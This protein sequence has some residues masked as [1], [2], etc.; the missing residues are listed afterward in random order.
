MSKEEKLEWCA[1]DLNFDFRW[2]IHESR[3]LHLIE[4]SPK[5]AERLFKINLKEGTSLSTYVQHLLTYKW[6]KEN[7]KENMSILC[8]L[9]ELYQDCKELRLRSERTSIEHYRKHFVNNE[10]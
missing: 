8:E 1:R 5:Y 10:Y 6:F 4:I 2:F 7:L 9:W 3:N